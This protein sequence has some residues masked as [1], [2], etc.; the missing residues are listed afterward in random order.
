MGAKLKAWNLF[1]EMDYSF[2]VFSKN[3]HLFDKISE[4]AF[5]AIANTAAL[6]LED[7]IIG[8]IEASTTRK[9]VNPETTN[10][11]ST[12]EV[13]SDGGPILQVPTR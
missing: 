13:G 1:I 12:T 11:L 6:T 7:G 5:S 8:I 2:K 9:F 10:L 4:A 3:V